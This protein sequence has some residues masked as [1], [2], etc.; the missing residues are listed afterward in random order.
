MITLFG[1]IEVTIKTEICGYVVF[2]QSLTFRLSWSLEIVV[3]SRI[4]SIRRPGFSVNR[5]FSIS[6]LLC[7]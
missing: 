2:E 7:C 6:W 5:K 1:I 3:L 4:R